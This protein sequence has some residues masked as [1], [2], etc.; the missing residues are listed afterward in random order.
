MTASDSQSTSNAVV[1]IT[2]LAVLG[3][4]FPARLLQLGFRLLQVVDETGRDRYRYVVPPV[5]AVP[6]GSFLLGSTFEQGRFD[7]T[8]QSVMCLPAFS[9]GTYPVTVAE[10]ACAVQAGEVAAPGRVQAVTWWNQLRHP[11]HPVV[12]L[13]WDLATDYAAWLARVTL[14]TWSIPTE[15]EWEK[16]ARGT[17]G[18][19][20]P[21]GEV[22]EP[23]RANTSESGLR[24]T[25][26]VGSYTQ[27]ASPYGVQ[28]MAG[29]VYE[30]TSTWYAR[31]PYREYDGREEVEQEVVED[32][33]DPPYE[34]RV[35]RGGSWRDDAFHARTAC[36]KKGHPLGGLA[37][38]DY[39]MRL[40]LR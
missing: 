34:H 37:M 29:N 30:W 3:E 15:A 6:A 36:R 26:P 4:Q 25:T 21:W 8:P 32:D 11:D 14:Q 16:A 39:G 7:E 22:W 13:T 28:D 10:Y 19:R 17:D 20:Y 5:R 18:R 2:Q 9:M 27:G 23:A 1:D 24:T 33:T 38:H 35:L 31:Y 12:C 40:I